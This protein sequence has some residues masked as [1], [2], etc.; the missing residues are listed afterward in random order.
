MRIDG[1]TVWLLV[2]VCVAGP[3]AAGELAGVTLPDRITVDSKTLVLN[4]MGLRE[5]TWLKVDVYVAG[6]YLEAKSSDPEAIL[7]SEQTKRLVMRFVRAVDR[8]ALLK[9]WNEGFEKS[10]GPSAAALR[11]RIATFESWVTDMPKD[12]GMSLTYLPGTGVQVEIKGQARGT[13]PGADF[14]RA[15]FRIW[16]GPTP[17]NPGLKEGLLGKG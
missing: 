10:A 16:L 11:D 4:G 2:G 12:E 3:A 9:G 14:A 6:L 1:A 5:A 15:L 8:D 13:V 17:P 7:G